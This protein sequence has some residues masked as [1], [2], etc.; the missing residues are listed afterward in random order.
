MEGNEDAEDF[1]IEAWRETRKVVNPP[2]SLL[3]SLQNQTQNK[4]VKPLIYDKNKFPFSNLGNKN[5]ASSSMASQIAQRRKKPLIP[6]IILFILIFFLMNCS[7]SC[8][9]R[10]NN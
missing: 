8:W 3:Q 10:S 1:E 4:I 2:S 7:F 9:S 5:S 6:S